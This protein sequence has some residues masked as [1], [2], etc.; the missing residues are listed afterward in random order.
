MIPSFVCLFFSTPPLFSKLCHISFPSISFPIWSFQ[1]FHFFD[2]F[3]LCLPPPFS[4]SISCFAPPSLFPAP[5]PLSPIYCFDK[6]IWVMLIPPLFTRADKERS[7]PVCS[8][9]GWF[10]SADTHPGY[11]D[12]HTDTHR[13]LQ[14]YISLGNSLFQGFVMLKN[15]CFYETV[16]RNFKKGNFS[17]TVFCSIFC[18]SIEMSWIQLP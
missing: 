18:D 9:W 2:I 15:I 10:Y 3:F 13:V 11:R 6:I 12:T 14:W 5:P 17:L 1:S 7:N 16:F 4:A 8:W